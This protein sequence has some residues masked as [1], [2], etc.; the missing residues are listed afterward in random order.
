MDRVIKV[1]I[2]QS[3]SQNEVFT[4]TDSFWFDYQFYMSPKISNVYKMYNLKELSANF[5]SKI[6]KMSQLNYLF[7]SRIIHLLA[8]SFS[9]LNRYHT[10]MITEFDNLRFFNPYNSE[11]LGYKFYQ[12][13]GAS[14]NFIKICT[15]L[16]IR[17]RVNLKKVSRFIKSYFF[18]SQKLF[19]KSLYEYNYGHT[20]F[21]VDQ[22]DWRKLLNKKR[23]DKLKEKRPSG[24]IVFNSKEIFRTH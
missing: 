4:C 2:K 14:Q 24:S 16:N 11:G 6:K 15:F 9:S 21:D 12:A 22:M 17:S 23:A 7:V 10:R 19:F 1:S 13:L 20:G 8:N 3:S 18:K 5:D